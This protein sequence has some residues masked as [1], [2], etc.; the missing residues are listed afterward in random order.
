VAYLEGW[1]A[2]RVVEDPKEVAA[3]TTALGMIKSCALSAT[4]HAA[5]L[6]RHNAQHVRRRVAGV[7]CV[8]EV[9]CAKLE[10]RQS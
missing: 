3:I 1:E 6:G 5:A 9:A 8:T 2:G 10:A 7:H 4:E